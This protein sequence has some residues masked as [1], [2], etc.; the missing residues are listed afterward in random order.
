[1]TPE[2]FFK[3]YYHSAVKCEADTKVPALAILSQAALESAWGDKAPGNMFFGI[4]AGADWKGKRQLITTREVHLTK[5]VKYPEVISIT[6]RADGKYDYR[7]RDWFRA[8]DNA[9]DSFV[10]HGKFLH[11][12]PRYAKAFQ[13]TDPRKFVDLI[14]I[15]GYATDPGYAKTLKDI[16]SMLEKFLPAV[17]NKA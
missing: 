17:S 5:N 3:L 9:A 4:K 11:E 1:M 7:V 10:D 13:T 6:A 12:S 2:S 8:Y 14:A 16:I 15:A